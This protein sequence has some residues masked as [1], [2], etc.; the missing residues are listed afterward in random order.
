MIFGRH[1]TIAWVGLL[2]VPALGIC[3]EPVKD[4]VQ[5][6]SQFRK[7]T[8]VGIFKE[9][10]LDLNGDRKADYAVHS[11]GGEEAYL[12]ILLADATGFTVW[13]FPTAED[14]RIEREGSHYQVILE[15]ST[16]PAYGSPW[17]GD[18][19]RWRDHYEIDDYSVVLVNSKYKQWYAAQ[20]QSYKSRVLEL[21][22]RQ[23]QLEQEKNGD[24]LALFESE[25]IEAQIGRYEGWIKNADAIVNGK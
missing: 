19:H 24:D 15:F 1:R 22:E 20:R 11:S 18:I 6:L 13:H 14:Y 2:L 21:R 8:E 23:R 16:F 7:S 3:D 9:E 12:S 10:K 25:R 17:G 4:H 5:D